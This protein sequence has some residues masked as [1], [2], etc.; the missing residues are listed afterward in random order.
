MRHAVYSH[1]QSVKLLWAILLPVTVGAG[2]SLLAEKGTAG[3]PGVSLLVLLAAATLL[4]MGHFTVEVG[5]GRIEWRFGAL[6]WPRWDAA[7]EQIIGVEVTTSSAF[8]GWGINRTKTGMLYN[9][10]GQQA[11]RLHLRDGRTLRLGSDEPERLAAFIAAR[12]PASTPARAG[13]RTR[14]R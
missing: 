13:E 14:P 8:E 1:T 2:V 12:Q 5:E 3:W 9:A 11:V 6:G 4:V 10:H 7:L